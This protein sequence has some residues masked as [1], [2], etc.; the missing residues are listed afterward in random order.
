M[1]IIAGIAVAA[2]FVSAEKSFGLVFSNPIY[3][4]FLAH[5]PHFNILNK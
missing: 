2:I 5:I 4:F 1:H 3:I